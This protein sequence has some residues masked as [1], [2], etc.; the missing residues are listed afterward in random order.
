MN[1]RQPEESISRAQ[2]LASVRRE[3]LRSGNKRGIQILPGLLKEAEP[4]G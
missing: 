1:E 4:R 2:F 3:N